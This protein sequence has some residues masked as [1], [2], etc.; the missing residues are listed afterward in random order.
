[1]ADKVHRSIDQFLEQ[2]EINSN[3]SFTSMKSNLRAQER[4]RQ[5]RSETPL[6]SYYSPPILG[7]AALKHPK[8]G[9]RTVKVLRRLDQLSQTREHLYSTPISTAAHHKLSQIPR[10]VFVGDQPGESQ[11]RLGIFAGLRGDDNAGPKAIAAFIDD[12]VVFPYLGRAFRIYAYPIVNPVS[13]ETETPFTQSGCNLINEIGRKVKSPEAYLIEREL[14]V[15]QFQGLIVIHTAEEIE[16]LQAGVYG[17][18]LHDTLVSPILSSLRSFFPTAEHSVV[19]SSWS[20][21]AD[22]GLKQRPF[23]LTLRIPSSGWQTLYSIGL[24]IA[25]HTA[26]DRYRS[27]LAQANNI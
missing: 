26:V 22:A 2:K 9:S 23:E 1:M 3:T 7:A 11:I 25:L 27:Y 24:R 20:L 21:T 15:V 8:S 4:P 12:L 19:D 17:A 14:F 5:E 13:F 10:Y 18:N 16:G 6:K